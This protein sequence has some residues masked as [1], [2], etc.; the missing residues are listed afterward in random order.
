MKTLAVGSVALL[1]GLGSWTVMGQQAGPGRG[2]RGDRPQFDPEQMRQ[3]MMERM[4][5]RLEVKDDA[6]WKAIEDRLQ[7]VMDARREAG[8]FGGMG[9]G[10]FGR[11][12][13][14]GG[15]GGDQPG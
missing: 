8:G 2:D 13:G 6:E 4:R 10:M 7:K 15:Q 14:R 5:E 3:R 12:P 11:G 1:I 9:M